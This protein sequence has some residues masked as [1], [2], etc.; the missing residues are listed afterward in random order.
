MLQT[1]QWEEHMKIEMGKCSVQKGNDF[2]FVA[3][4]FK[5]VTQAI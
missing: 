4:Y 5:L 3:S 1:T 2:I